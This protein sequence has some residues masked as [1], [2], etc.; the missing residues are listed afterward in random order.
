MRGEKDTLLPYNEFLRRFAGCLDDG[1]DFHR[2][3]VAETKL[4]AFDRQTAQHRQ[5][6]L[7]RIGDPLIDSTEEYLR[8]DD[9]GIC[10]AMWR[11]R[12]TIQLDVPAAIAF[13]FDIVAE[14]DIAPLGDLRKD[15]PEASLTALRRRADMAFPPIVGQLWLDSDLELLTEANHRQVYGE[16]YRSTPLRGEPNAGQDYN[17]NEQRWKQANQYCDITVWRGLCYSAREKAEELLREESRMPAIIREC[18]A[19]ATAGI[20]GA[21]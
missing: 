2:P 6:R 14:A 19:K 16:P 21:D 8:W 3:V 1:D 15:W 18:S 10:F 9:R 4:V 5:T 12:P 17:L 7:A 11:Y 13:R 20:C